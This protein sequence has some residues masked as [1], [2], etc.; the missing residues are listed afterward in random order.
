MAS[1]LLIVHKK[2]VPDYLEKVIETRELLA[3]HEASSVTEAVQI[4]GISRNTFYKYKNYVWRADEISSVQRAII[5]LVL[6][7]EPGT[8]SEVLKV[9]FGAN[10]SVIT[11]SQSIPVASKAAVTIS[12]DISHIN[13]KVEDLIDS[14]R[15]LENVMNIQL[16]A[17][18]S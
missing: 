9:L 5:S 7:D 16:D 11:I 14:L 15:T 2:I 13:G 18:G 10:V 3:R 17:I 1:D 4:T 8:L 6:K 12:M